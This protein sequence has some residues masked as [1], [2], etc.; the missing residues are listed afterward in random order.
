[1]AD[2]DPE[3]KTDV[4][5]PEPADESSESE[6]FDEPPKRKRKSKQPSAK[7]S[8]SKSS[9]A[10][11]STSKSTAAES[12]SPLSE[13]AD[14]DSGVQTDIKKPEPADESSESEVFD[15]PPKR[16]RKSKEPATK[17]S[18][19]KSSKPKT[20]ASKSTADV[21]PDDAEIKKLQSQLVK[22]GVR[23]IWAFELKQ[24]GDDSRAKIRH[25]K[26]MLKDIGMDGRFSE[27][28]AREIKER[29]ELLADLEEVQEMSKNWG[30]GDGRNSRSRAARP[31]KLVVDDDDDDDEEDSA[32]KDD[33]D[34]DE[35]ED[36]G[37]RN[38]R[39]AAIAKRRADFAFLGDEEES[40]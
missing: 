32:P 39:A 36:E 29:R 4:K 30:S 23:K 33:S 20:S 12:D 21:S 1:L 8:A 40:D 17:K 18:A 34:G 11:T 15:E 31:K 35:D 13:L 24:Y 37:P 26:G 19:G 25:L 5:K 7:K 2:E 27:S 9:K 16:K 10:K 6:V 28:K 22:C 3:I 14:E 38:P